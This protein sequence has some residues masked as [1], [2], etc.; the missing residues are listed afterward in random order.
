MRAIK[1]TS[2]SLVV[3]LIFGIATRF[4]AARQN[5]VPEYWYH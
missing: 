2:I 4:A 5:K 1:L 3:V